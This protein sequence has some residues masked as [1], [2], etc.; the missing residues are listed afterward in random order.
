MDY[1]LKLLEWTFWENYKEIFLQSC[2]FPHSL[3][4]A[5]YDLFNLILYVGVNQHLDML[6]Q[7]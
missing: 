4:A 7:V 3:T 5:T 2:D 1:F 6:D